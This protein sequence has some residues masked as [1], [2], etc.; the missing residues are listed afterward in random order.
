MSSSSS[1]ISSSEDGEEEK[2]EREKVEKEY[3]RAFELLKDMTKGKREVCGHL[4]V[5]DVPVPF[6][7]SKE[8]SIVQPPFPCLVC[9]IICNKREK[10]IKHAKQGHQI[11]T[12]FEEEG[13]EV[14]DKGIGTV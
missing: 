5:D 1:S 9:G 12:R 4:E 10:A 13:K 2:E 6:C 8:D 3:Q 14:R 11:G 7:V